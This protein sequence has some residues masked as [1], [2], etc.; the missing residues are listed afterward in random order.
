MQ[1]RR[2]STQ[3][4]RE[5]ITSFQHE[6]SCTV[7]CHH[8]AGHNPHVPTKK[9]V[10]S[11]ELCSPWQT[12][13]ASLQSVRMKATTLYMLNNMMCFVPCD[14]SSFNHSTIFLFQRR[15]HAQSTQATVVLATSRPVLASGSRAILH[16]GFKYFP[17]RR[18][19]RSLH[20]PSRRYQDDKVTRF[21][22]RP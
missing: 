6:L 19:I 13:F 5:S 4:L 12:L 7:I 3:V 8:S 20:G 2:D 18:T 15:R 9:T 22:V 11:T 16:Q 10:L 14:L 21:M 1:E 17:R